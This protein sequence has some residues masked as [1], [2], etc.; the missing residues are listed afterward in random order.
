LHLSG[1]PHFRHFDWRN[2]PSFRNYKWNKKS[3]KF[4]QSQLRPSPPKVLIKAT[5]SFNVIRMIFPCPLTGY[6]YLTTDF[7]M[8]IAGNQKEMTAGLRIG[9]TKQ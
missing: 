7:Y 6:G 5:D 1:L 8:L 4:H 3:V 2:R 9:A